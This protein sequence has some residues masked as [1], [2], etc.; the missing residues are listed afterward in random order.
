MKTVLPQPYNHFVPQQVSIKYGKD[1]YNTCIKT[2]WWI[3][4]L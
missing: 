1:N 2:T 4:K 3:Y